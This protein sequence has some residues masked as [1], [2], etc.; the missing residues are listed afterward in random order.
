M[1]IFLFF[2]NIYK[3]IYLCTSKFTRNMW[4]KTFFFLFILS[5]VEL[6]CKTEV[7]PLQ[8]DTDSIPN[9]EKLVKINDK[10]FSIPSPVQVSKLVKNLNL[11]YNKELLNSPKNYANYSTSFKRALNL[12]IYGANLGYLHI[13]EQL[14]DAAQ[15]LA[16]IKMLSKDLDLINSFNEATMKRIEGSKNNKD[17][18]IYIMSNVYRNAD[19]YL[20]NNERTDIG[21]L[22]LAGGWIETLFM[23]TQLSKQSKDKELVSRI[24]EQKHPLDNLI[25]LLRPYYG[26]QQSKEFDK[27]LESL[28]DLATTYD[29][30]VIE[31]SFEKPTVFADKKLTVINSKTKTIINEQ[32]L[33]EITRMV[34]TIRGKIVE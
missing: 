24:G 16:T 32:Q 18:L 3:K 4:K 15:Y 19:S 11:P 31:Y 5:L 17:S 23:M 13:Y 10:L 30:V 33:K 6:S 34:A 26:K 29:G 7:K 2:N 20:M 8:T 22:I 21:V 27:F 14:P 25:E 1:V 9:E 28:V 12:G